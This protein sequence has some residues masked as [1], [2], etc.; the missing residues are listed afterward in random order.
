MKR[1][2]LAACIVFAGISLA[3]IG[4]HIFADEQPLAGYSVESS[5]TEKQWEEKM[6]AIPEPDNVRD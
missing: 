6:R 1:K 5:Q 4:T 3:P 2:G